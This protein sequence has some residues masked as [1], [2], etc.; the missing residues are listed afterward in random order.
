M[1]REL[2]R[3]LI[4]E[5]LSVID[6]SQQYL[7]GV[8]RRT[9]E[10]ALR[11]ALALLDLREGIE[12]LQKRLNPQMAWALNNHDWLPI[13]VQEWREIMDQ[14]RALLPKPTTEKGAPQSE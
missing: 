4:T 10:A 13:I 6:Q 5:E 9:Y 12:R 11:D 3:E 14:L 7:V 2:T 1:T 8:H